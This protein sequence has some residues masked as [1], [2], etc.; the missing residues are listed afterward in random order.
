MNV[1]V[2]DCVQR[3]QSNAVREKKLLRIT[4]ILLVNGVLKKVSRMFFPIVLLLCQPLY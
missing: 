2:L 4:L 1:T 3:D